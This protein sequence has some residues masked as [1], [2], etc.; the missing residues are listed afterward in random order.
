MPLVGVFVRVA[1]PA[2]RGRFRC[3]DRPT[4]SFAPCGALAAG[5]RPGL[6]EGDVADEVEGVD[7]QSPRTHSAS[8]SSN[9]PPR[10]RSSGGGWPLFATDGGAGVPDATS[11]SN[12]PYSALRRFGGRLKA[13]NDSETQVAIRAATLDV[14]ATIF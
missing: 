6:I 13:S 11:C 8:S 12:E 2:L 9:T 4:L 14:S 7:I 1:R 3:T 10:S 5:Q